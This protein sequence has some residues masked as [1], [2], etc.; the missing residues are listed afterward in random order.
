MLIANY[1]IDKVFELDEIRLFFLV[2]SIY[3]LYKQNFQTTTL[4][5]HFSP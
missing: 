3:Y 1:A 2:H 5:S 4:G